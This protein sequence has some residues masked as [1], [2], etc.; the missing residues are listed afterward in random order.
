MTDHEEEGDDLTKISWG[1]EDKGTWM[2]IEDNTIQFSLT[3]TRGRISLSP[4]GEVWFDTYTQP[5]A[6]SK[7][8]IVQWPL[9]WTAQRHKQRL[10]S[11][12]KRECARTF[13]LCSI[14]QQWGIPK[15]VLWMI[16]CFLL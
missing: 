6:I 5:Y 4:K 15:Q 3:G 16:L 11:P 1:E 10:I 7:R 14:R 13:M 2:V 9:K 12:L 8:D